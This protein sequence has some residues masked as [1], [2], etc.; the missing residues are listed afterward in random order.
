MRELFACMPFALF[1]SGSRCM[2]FAHIVAHVRI[3]FAHTRP[4]RSLALLSVAA[5]PVV[6]FVPPVYTIRSPAQDTC[7]LAQVGFHAVAVLRR[8]L[9]IQVR[10]HPTHVATRATYVCAFAL[11][12]PTWHSFTTRSRSGMVR[13]CLQDLRQYVKGRAVLVV[14][15]VGCLHTFRALRSCAR[16]R[17]AVR[18][19][20]RTRLRRIYAGML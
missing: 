10:T 5:R 13:P 18:L 12:V 3:L 8:S 9:P 4:A 1:P 14:A 20:Y 15:C 2:L 7:I 16:Q 19:R 11:F 17:C 6:L